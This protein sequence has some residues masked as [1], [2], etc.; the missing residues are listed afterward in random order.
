MPGLTGLA[1]VNKPHHVSVETHKMGFNW[2]MEYIEDCSF[3][4]DLC[5]MIST[6][7]VVI[8]RKGN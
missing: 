2:D 3:L 1:Q 6:V 4:T 8:K 5:I 7:S